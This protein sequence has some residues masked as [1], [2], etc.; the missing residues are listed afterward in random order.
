MLIYPMPVAF[1]SEVTETE[2]FDETIFE[3]VIKCYRMLS[4]LVIKNADTIKINSKEIN[5]IINQ[6][7]KLL[8][9]MLS[10][11]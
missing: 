8:R 6:R 11:G 3:E 9:R 1:A 5:N 2:T 10:A 4:I 7:N